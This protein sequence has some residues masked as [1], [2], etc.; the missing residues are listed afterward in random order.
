MGR[1]PV[2]YSGL[3]WEKTEA[4]LLINELTVWYVICSKQQDAAQSSKII[5]NLNSLQLVNAAGFRQVPS[6][7]LDWLTIWPGSDGGSD[8]TH[9]LPISADVAGTDGALN[10]PNPG[11][12]PSSR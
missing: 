11:E 1:R 3:N 2:V 4:V 6:D 5:T 8:E 12:R 10:Q 7:V 9:G